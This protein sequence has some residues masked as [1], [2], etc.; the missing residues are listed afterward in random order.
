MGRTYAGEAQAG[1]SPLGGNP[2]WSS[3]RM[4]HPEDEAMAETV[5][6]ELTACSL[7]SLSPCVAEREKVEN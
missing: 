6:Y 7:H 3:R 1:W 4:L 2:R 5:C